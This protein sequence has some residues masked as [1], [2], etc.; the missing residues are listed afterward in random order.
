[1]ILV[2]Q[3]NGDLGQSNGDL[4]WGKNRESCNLFHHLPN[5]VLNNISILHPSIGPALAA[6]L[7]KWRPKRLFCNISLN[8]YFTGKSTEINIILNNILYIKCSIHFLCIL[9]GF[10]AMVI[11]MDPVTE[12]L[13]HLQ[14][15][16]RASYKKICRTYFVEYCFQNNIYI[17][18]F[19]SKVSIKKC[20]YKKLFLSA[21]FPRW[22]SQQ[23]RQRGAKLI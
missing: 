21:I 17:D 4:R 7:E 8:N 13:V 2:G 14:H 15:Q 5:R 16:N 9:H 10:D 1:M 23:G 12:I 11:F 3:L 22:R 19:S 20:I 6:I 18:P